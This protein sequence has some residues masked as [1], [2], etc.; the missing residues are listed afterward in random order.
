MRTIRGPA[1]VFDTLAV[2]T[3][4]LL[5]A[6]M[7]IEQVMES[8]PTQ[9]MLSGPCVVFTSL[10]GCDTKR[11]K[12]MVTNPGVEVSE[13]VARC[14][15]SHMT[16]SQVSSTRHRMSQQVAPLGF[17]SWGGISVLVEFLKRHWG[18]CGCPGSDGALLDPADPSSTPTPQ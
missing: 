9:S 15:R 2:T 7:T 6:G 10:S 18:V 3:T 8:F 16:F 14:F 4:I 1:V 13:E 5:T 11:C 12:Q 17:V